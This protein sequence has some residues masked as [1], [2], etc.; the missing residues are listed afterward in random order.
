MA[1]LKIG[2]T[3][4]LVAVVC[5]WL[6]DA[7]LRPV[8]LA[9]QSPLVTSGIE[10]LLLSGV[11]VSASLLLY[12]RSA[13]GRHNGSSQYA[14]E[15]EDA[16]AREQAAL[17]VAQ[18]QQTL[19]NSMAEITKVGAWELDLEARQPIWSAQT[20][21]IHEV[22]D[23]YVPTFE[24]AVNF[25]APEVRPVIQ[26]AVMK[27]LETGDP[28]DLEL[29]LIT[30]KGRRI[31]VRAFGRAVMENGKPVKLT[32]A[33]QDITQ[34]RAE[35]ETL[36]RALKDADQALAN[37]SAYQSA[38]DQHAIVAMTDAKGDI[39]F[40]NNKF[41]ELSGYSREELIGANHRMLNSGRHSLQFFADMWRTIGRGRSWHAEICNKAKDGGLYWVDTTIVPVLD[42]DGLPQQFVSIHYDITERKNADVKL[43]AAMS[44]IAGFFEVSLDLLCI[45]DLDGRF[46]K[47]N[48]AFEDVL[49]YPVDDLEGRSF[50]SLVHPD[51]LEETQETLK[52]LDTGERAIN[53]VNRYLCANGGYR[54]IEWR[55]RSANGR[56][57]AAARDITDRLTHAEE[58]EAR[59]LEAEA[60]NIAKSQFL[61]TMSH[62]IR[63]PMNGVMGMLDLLIKTDLTEEQLDRAM[64]ARDS[65]RGLLT[66]LNDILDFSKLEA[67]QVAMEAMPL[68][69]S[70]IVNDIVSLL[71]ARSDE[72]GLSLTYEID[73]TVPDWLEGDPTRMRQILINLIGNA[74]KFTQ[75][76]RVDIHA[77]YEGGAE[78]G[79]LKISVRDTGIGIDEAVQDRLFQRFAQAD[80]STTRKFGGTGLGLAICKQLV[81]LMGGQIGIES[82]LGKG[83]TFW[84]TIPTRA[85]D[86]PEHAATVEAEAD[87]APA[88]TRSLRI[89]AAED[90][91]V[92][93]AIISAFVTAGGH[94]ITVVNN[95]AEALAAV[96]S[97]DFDL[98]LMDIQMPVMDGLSAMRAIRGL[99]GA[100]KHIPIIALTANAMAGDREKYLAEGMTDY[101]SKPI[102]PAKLLSV[103]DRWAPDAAGSGRPLLCRSAPRNARFEEETRRADPLS[104]RD[105]S[106]GANI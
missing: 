16:R 42:K 7:A 62:E 26:R 13:D 95:G 56:I 55:S 100:L 98:I 90:H 3:L 99:S 1:S 2:G 47:V 54:Y 12:R 9:S 41:C 52:V 14:T 104:E 101:V 70:Q 73:R 25:Y 103:I 11:L 21:V 79:S 49:G 24:E 38:L 4:A 86:A 50:Q 48:K 83:S 91:A 44:E 5:D 22:D 102:D 74:V 6:L 31:W 84:F 30:A 28:W 80:S 106:V 68:S 33:F 96:Q 89:L 71:T 97:H 45:A 18:S 36:A 85:L 34:Q 19:L 61:A 40:V 46:L 23:D 37:L 60:A 58:L 77:G 20:R 35:R 29:P 81:E 53:F 78:A 87:R 75:E 88:A 76:G 93:Q 65:A 10:A 69:V 94:D 67:G 43:H 51:D 105:L 57:Y 8:L 32:G 15:I 39:T 64:T 59:R 72:K 63:T 92:N 27:G 82:A 66:I 17:A